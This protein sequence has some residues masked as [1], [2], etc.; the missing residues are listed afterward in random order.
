MA[1]DPLGPGPA[2]ASEAEPDPG[3][4]MANRRFAMLLVFVAIVGVVTSLVAWCFLELVHQ[5]QTGVFTDLPKDLGYE[6]GAPN[7]WY[8]VML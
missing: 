3:E 5:I 8:L 4:V 6:G 1:E 7:W 2:P